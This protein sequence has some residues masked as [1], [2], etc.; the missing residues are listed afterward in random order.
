M[1]TKHRF[2][3]SEQTRE[4]RL[5]KQVHGHLHD[6]VSLQECYTRNRKEVCKEEP[7]SLASVLE[8][9]IKLKNMR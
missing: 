6:E 9:R 3:R 4:Q 2:H 8:A 1:M 7:R 5:A